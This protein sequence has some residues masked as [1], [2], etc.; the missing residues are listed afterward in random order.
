MFGSL[1]FF[2][3]TSIPVMPLND[4]W[5]WFSLNI[6]DINGPSVKMQE[7]IFENRK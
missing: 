3:S 7:A 1:E 4:G 5:G 6:L 2:K